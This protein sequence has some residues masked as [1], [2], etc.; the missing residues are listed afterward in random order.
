MLKYLQGRQ[1]E[2]RFAFLPLPSTI[3]GGGCDGLGK[4]SGAFSWWGI[5]AVS[6]VF[7]PKTANEKF[8]NCW[9]YVVNMWLLFDYNNKKIKDKTSSL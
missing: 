6:W 9:K 1:L 5:D 8:Q 7:F 2:F 3:S 4:G